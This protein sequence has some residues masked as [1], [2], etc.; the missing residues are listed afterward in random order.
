MLVY[1]A[2][3]VVVEYR[4]YVAAYTRGL[5]PH[6]FTL[7]ICKITAYLCNMG[8]AA[9]G[10]FLLLQAWAFTHLRFPQYNALSC[11]DFPPD[12]NRA[13]E[14][15]AKAAKV[16]ILLIATKHLYMYPLH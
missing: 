8:F 16:D 11:P 6:I 15:P 9:G 1:M 7:A 2:L 14:Q 10:Y 3:Q 4:I 12:I 5:L 13:I